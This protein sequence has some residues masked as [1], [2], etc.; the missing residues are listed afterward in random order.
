[1]IDTKYR[2]ADKGEAT[3]ELYYDGS[4]IRLGKGGYA[5]DQNV[6]G[7]QSV[8]KQL[9]SYLQREGIRQVDVPIQCML[10][11]L[12]WM[13]DYTAAMGSGTK[14]QSLYYNAEYV[15]MWKSH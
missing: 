15:E 14:I 6:K 11:Y 4:R 12:G 5:R 7:I 3:N 8:K 2:R 1:M 13:V 10:V 9:I